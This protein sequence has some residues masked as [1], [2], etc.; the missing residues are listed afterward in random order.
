MGQGSNGKIVKAREPLLTLRQYIGVADVAVQIFGHKS[1][2][3][4]SGDG[5]ESTVCSI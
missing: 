3:V 2:N 5:G 1:P 4:H